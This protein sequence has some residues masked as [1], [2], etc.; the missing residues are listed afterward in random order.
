MISKVSSNSQE[1]LERVQSPSAMKDVSS[2]PGSLYKPRGAGR[3]PS[4]PSV[5]A[6]M[7]SGVIPVNGRL[8]EKMCPCLLGKVKTSL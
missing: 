3:H 6:D 7:G 5:H 2:E 4:S 1:D 8:Q